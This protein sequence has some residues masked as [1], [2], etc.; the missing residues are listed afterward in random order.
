MDANC[1]GKYNN[2]YVV[3]TTKGF[4]VL[5]NDFNYKAYAG[6]EGKYVVANG[7]NLYTLDLTNNGQMKSYTSTDLTTA[8]S[9]VN[10]TSAITDRQQGCNGYRRQRDVCLQG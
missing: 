6:A 7:S 9:T 1:V 4:T 5:D 3:A 8:A 2:N 10:T